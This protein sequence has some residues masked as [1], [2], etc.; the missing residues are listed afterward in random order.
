VTPVQ[1]RFYM[2]MDTFSGTTVNLDST[3]DMQDAS[4]RCRLRCH[5]ADREEGLVHEPDRGKG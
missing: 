1:N 2:V 5:A 3:T 4:T